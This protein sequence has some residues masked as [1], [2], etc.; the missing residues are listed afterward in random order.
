MSQPSLSNLFAITEENLKLRREFVQLGPKEA[1]LLKPLQGWA[2]TVAPKIARE[3]Y[4]FQFGFERTRI[5][6]ERMAATKGMPLDALRKVLEGAQA[7]YLIQVFEGANTGWD[8]KYFEARLNVGATH[9]RINLPT[10]WYIGSYSLYESLVAK[11]LAKKVRNP[12]KRMKIQRVINRVFNLDMQAVTDSYTLSLFRSM[13]VD[14]GGIHV[15]AQTDRSEMIA[16]IKNDINRAL[17]EMTKGVERVRASASELAGIAASMHES[18][19]EV[20][21]SAKEV[22]VAG[23][24][25]AEN[26]IAACAQAESV[27]ALSKDSYSAITEVREHS[28]RTNQILAMIEEVSF[29]INLLALN[30][31]VE[32]ARAG[33]A[34]TGFAVVAS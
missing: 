1:R 6:F 21:S 4:D 2:R 32:A 11:Y 18:S 8:M 15:D 27:S 22:S 9:D 5:F 25:I 13:G 16:G 26:S 10:K 20:A 30:A 33:E 29:Q 14:V 12:F 28:D 19:S 23:Q 3:F 24:H 31:A 34:G 17:R 7:G